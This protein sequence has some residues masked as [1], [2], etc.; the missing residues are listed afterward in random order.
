[1]VDLARREELQ[2]DVRQRLVQLAHD[3][4]VVVEAHVRRLAADHVDLGE[5]R[6]LVLADG[7]LDEL[8]RRVRVR[9]GLLLRHRERAELALHAA[10]VRLVQVQVLDEVHL[11]AA[12]APAAREVGELAE[13]EEVVG[14]HQRQPVLEVE[15]L[16]RLD[17]LA[18]P[19]QRVG[20]FQ[21]GHC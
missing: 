12:A 21:Q 16:V 10:D 3:L 15:P 11:V 4:D 8:L 7:V 5:P 9:V 1:V 19:G 18:D 17:L 6:Q 2:V 14:L 20:P 13:C